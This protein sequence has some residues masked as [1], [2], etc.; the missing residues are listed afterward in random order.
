MRII[1]SGLLA[2]L[3]SAMTDYRGA[4][5]SVAVI[6]GGLVGPLH[7]ILLA[8]K[9]LH[10]DLYEARKDIRRLQHTGGRRINLGLSVRGREALRAVGLDDTVLDS[11]IPTNGRMIHSLSG[12]MYIQPYRK[13]QCVYSIDRQKLSELLLTKAEAKPGVSIHF[14]HKLT[15]ANLEEKTLVF[16]V[17]N[18][19][20][21][22][23]IVNTDFVFGCDGA[24]STV[25]RQMMRWGRLNYSQEYIEHGYKE[26]TLPPTASGGF[27]LA[28]NYLHFWP[29]NKFLVVALPN[30]DRTFTLALFMPFRVFDSIETE[31]DLLVFF[32]KHFPDL[33][34]KIGVERLSQDYFRNPTGRLISVKCYP[35]FMAGSTVILGDAAHA[36]VPFYGQGMNAGFEDCLT[37]YNLLE[38][39][40]N[41]LQKAAAKYSETRWKDSYA[42]A[43]LSLNR[44]IEIRERINSPI[45]LLR[46]YL[47]NILHALFPRTFIPLETMVIHTRLPYHTA[48]ERNQSQTSI[49]NK[50]LLF[51]TISSLIVLGYATFRYK[52]YILA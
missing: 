25:R 41:D 34:D 26:L 16:Q 7:A 2:A 39:F 42:I 20:V 10:V 37:F 38:Q 13:D 4:S 21:Q 44:Y 22:E 47:D 18:Q 3:A 24:H 36:V 52:M 51:L 19:N 14:E 50:T 28:T 45:F 27:A 46:R 33:V 11:A 35:H 8:Q 29:R 43:D 17:G 1:S 40:D 32:T 31:E 5:T 12:E 9:G 49:I 6:G 30:Q 15:R 48:I 23:K